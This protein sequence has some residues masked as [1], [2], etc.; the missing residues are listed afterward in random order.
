M[1]SS[2][3]YEMLLWLNNILTSSQRKSEFKAIM[4][5]NSEQLICTFAV[6]R[7]SEQNGN[8]FAIIEKFLKKNS[9]SKSIQHFLLI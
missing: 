7:I 8:N 3:F 2:K 4:W 5:K 6:S 9:L 1:L